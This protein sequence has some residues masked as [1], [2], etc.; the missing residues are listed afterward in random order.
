MF[1]SDNNLVSSDMS[2]TAELEGRQEEPSSEYQV[3][4]FN[5]SLVLDQNVSMQVGFTYDNLTSDI[6]GKF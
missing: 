1:D 4:N 2:G 3:F 6:I 5:L